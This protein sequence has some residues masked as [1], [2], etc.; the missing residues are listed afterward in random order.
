MTSGMGETFQQVGVAVGIAAFGALFHHRVFD[1][2]TASEAAAQLGAQTAEFGHAVVAGAGEELSKTLAPA[3]ATQVAE[4]ARFAFVDGFTS[5]MGVCAAVCAVGALIAFVLIRRSD[6]HESAL[7]D[8][9]EPDAGQPIAATQ[10][11]APGGP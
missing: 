8:A 11:V 10:A 7:S 5:V 6:L 2:F 4:A 1:T 9:A 3:L